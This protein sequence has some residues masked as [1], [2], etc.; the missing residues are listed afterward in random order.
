MDNVYI[1]YVKVDF[2]N[3]VIDVNSSAFLPDT[4]GWIEIDGGIGDKYHHAQGNYFPLPIM[5]S[6]AGC[7]CPTATRNTVIFWAPAVN[8]P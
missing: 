8:A 1:V 4:E 3:R 2:E 7:M 5:T 6:A